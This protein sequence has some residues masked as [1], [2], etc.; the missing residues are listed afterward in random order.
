VARIASRIIR[1]LYGA[2]IHWDA[3]LAPGVIVVH[4]NGLVISHAARV[5][6]GCVLFQH[7]TLG[8]SIHP[9]T[10]LV[11]A[12]TLE[13]GVHVGAGA[14]LVGPITIGQGTKIMANAVL[15]R[16][17]P[18]HS[19]VETPAATIRPRNAAGGDGDSVTRG[20]PQR[21]RLESTDSAPTIR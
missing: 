14:V 4:G 19:L 9:D 3:E 2:E 7:V 17:V 12:P 13:P 6:V 1:H 5:G 16:S 10:R 15:V 11:G 18:P 20:R 8:E 21:V